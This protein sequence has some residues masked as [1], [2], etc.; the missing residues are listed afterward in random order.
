MLNFLFLLEFVFIIN[1]FIFILFILCKQITFYYDLFVN[2]LF[3]LN[4]Y[5]YLNMFYL[6]LFLFSWFITSLLILGDLEFFLFS[7]S[8]YSNSLINLLKIF[9]IFFFFFVILVSF[10]YLK[11]ANLFAISFEFIIIINLSIIGSLI[12]LSSNDF[13]SIFLGLELQSLSFYVL[14]AYKQTSIFSIEAGLKYFIL[15]SFS[16]GIFVFGISLLYGFLGIYNLTDLEFFFCLKSSIILLTYFF[17]C[18]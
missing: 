2:R 8:I 13:L 5:I 11:I 14:A 3:L 12:L 10:E 4:E 15:G 6:F 7:F 16:S 1:F 9:I 17:Y 18:P